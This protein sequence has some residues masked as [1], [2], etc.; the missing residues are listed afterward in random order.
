MTAPRAP[1]PAREA[2]WEASLARTAATPC[3]SPRG[4]CRP[5][6][7]D[8]L[9]SAFLAPLLDLAGSQ[10]VL[11]REPFVRVDVVQAPLGIADRVQP[12]PGPAPMS[13]AFVR[14][15]SIPP[16]ARWR[17]ESC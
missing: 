17:R 9:L 10:L 2:G 11:P 3:R 8:E 14:H 7:L 6:A 13:R 5:R 4:M 16:S 12:L 15:E 1:I